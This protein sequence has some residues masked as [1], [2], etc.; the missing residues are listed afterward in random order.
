MQNSFKKAMDTEVEGS[1]R[2]RANKSKT[3]GKS[4]IHGDSQKSRKPEE[5]VSRENKN[6]IY[7]QKTAVNSKHKTRHKPKAARK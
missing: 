7:D 2:T 6:A 3:Q 4:V 5:T 1:L